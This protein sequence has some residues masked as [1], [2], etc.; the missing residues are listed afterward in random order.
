M[1]TVGENNYALPLMRMFLDYQRGIGFKYVVFHA[2]LAQTFSGDI[3]L[4][5]LSSLVSI[6]CGLT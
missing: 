5:S 6:F 2:A 1:V 3:H 4:G